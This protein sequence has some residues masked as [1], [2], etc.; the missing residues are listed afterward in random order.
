MELNQSPIVMNVLV[1]CD[2]FTKDVMAYVNPNQTMKTVAKF[3]WQGYTLIFRAPAKLLSD[4]VA[5]FEINIIRELCE[6]MGI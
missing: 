1:F 2:H 3:L 6:L 5:N 4:Q